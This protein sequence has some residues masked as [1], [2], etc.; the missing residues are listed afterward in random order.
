[1]SKLACEHRRPAAKNRLSAAVPWKIL[2]LLLKR[3]VTA[4]GVF[5]QSREVARG[6]MVRKRGL[7][8]KGNP[9]PLL[10]TPGVHAG[11]TVP[12]QDAPGK[13]ALSGF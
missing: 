13:M 3:P 12:V 10:F 8:E 1:M 7:S 2:H 6:C 5:P 4:L 9:I 11:A